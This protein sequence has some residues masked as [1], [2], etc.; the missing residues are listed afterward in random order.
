MLLAQ[1]E[2]GGNVI[3]AASKHSWEAGAVALI[4]I[5]MA[6][7][8]WYLLR[9]MWTINQR[10]ADR[11][12]H[13]ENMFSEKMVRIVEST[14]DAISG[15]TRMMEKTAAAI[16]KL[17]AAVERSLET[18]NVIMTRMETSPCLMASV[19][20]DET[21]RRLEEARKAALAKAKAIRDDR[22]T[23]R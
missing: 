9:G 13:L 18:Q 21:T 4:L 16:D 11:V 5:A 7:G 19:M 17:E 1:I 2:G 3:D 20:S 23:T 12:T 14:T 15:N 10:L 8:L 6:S 22:K